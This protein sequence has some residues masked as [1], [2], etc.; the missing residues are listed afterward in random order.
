MVNLRES[1]KSAGIELQGG[2]PSPEDLNLNNPVCNAG[3]SQLIRN[4]LI[5]SSKWLFCENL[6]NLREIKLP[7]IGAMK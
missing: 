5:G 2:N 7:G 3:E 4:W 1:V 6:Y